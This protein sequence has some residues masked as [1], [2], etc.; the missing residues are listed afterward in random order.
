M[1]TGSQKETKSV[2]A[3]LLFTITTSFG[4]DLFE[5][6]C[7]F[8]HMWILFSSKPVYMWGKA[9]QM[10]TTA[11]TQTQKMESIAGSVNINS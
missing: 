3:C 7:Y 4:K 11:C 1:T 6:L 5:K 8:I 9:K 2:K 10:L